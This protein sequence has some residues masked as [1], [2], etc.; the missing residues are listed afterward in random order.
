MYEVYENDSSHE[1]AIFQ[2]LRRSSSQYLEITLDSFS[3]GHSRLEQNTKSLK[4]QQFIQMSRIVTY[5]YFL[6]IFIGAVSYFIT[7]SINESTTNWVN[8]FNEVAKIYVIEE[9]CL[10]W[11]GICVIVIGKKFL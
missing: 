8:Y 7:I 6:C 5:S 4:H 10:W 11:T 1:S 2:K 3:S 9:A